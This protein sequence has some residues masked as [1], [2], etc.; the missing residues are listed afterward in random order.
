[1]SAHVSA[2]PVYGRRL[3]PALIDERAQTRHERPYAS[4]PVSNDLADGFRDISYTVFASAINRCSAWLLQAKGRSTS[5]ETLAYIGPQDLRYQILCI[6]A[7]KVG[8]VVS[9]ISFGS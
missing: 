6:A 5:F 9:D 7:V 3:L 2:V 4:I 1:M 8:Y